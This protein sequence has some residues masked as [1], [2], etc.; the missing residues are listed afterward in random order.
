MMWLGT[1]TG[2]FYGLHHPK[3]L[4]DD[5]IIQDGINVYK[6]LTED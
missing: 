2:D 4:P 5:S 6:R 3:F 1:R